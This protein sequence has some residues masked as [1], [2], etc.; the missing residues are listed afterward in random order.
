MATPAKGKLE[1]LFGLSMS[2][3]R[4]LILGLICT[5]VSGKVD[6]ERVAALAPYK[7]VSS[8]SSSYGQAKRKLNSLNPELLSSGSGTAPTPT[9]KR[10]PAKATPRKTPTKR[11]RTGAAN[12]DAASPDGGP[13]TEDNM[14]S[15]TPKPKLQRKSLAENAQPAAE[16]DENTNTNPVKREPHQPV[17]NAIMSHASKDTLLSMS[18]KNEEEQLMTDLDVEAEFTAMGDER[19]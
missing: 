11:K 4:L 17:L 6:F 14:L 3:A 1:G 9:E 15:P 19:G 13:A 16:G 7:N 5:D 2:E 10:T 12:A 18:I 8:A